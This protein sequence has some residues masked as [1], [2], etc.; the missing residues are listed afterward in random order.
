MAKEHFF[1]SESARLV[2]GLDQVAQRVGASR[3]AVFD[4]WLTMI[5]CALA[6]GTMEAEYLTVVRRY[7]NSARDADL[8]NKD[9]PIDQL[10]AMFGELVT[11]MEA[12]SDILGD[13]FQGAITYGENGQFFTPDCICDLMAR[14]V[15]HD[16]GDTL[17]EKVCDPCCGS[18]R[19]LLATAKVNPHR[20]FVGQDVDHRCAKMTAIN[21]ALN[22]LYGESICGNSLS[23]EVRAAYRIGWNGAGFISR[24][25]EIALATMQAPPAAVAPPAAHFDDLP[26]YAGQ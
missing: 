18:G 8:L 4:D 6:G 15:A 9:R 21:L 22:G 14:M 13:I 12:R 26:L 10:A 1:H 17:K 20:Y 7:G 5:V 24:V 3:G 2:R 11:A 16:E 23:L 19:M 25:P